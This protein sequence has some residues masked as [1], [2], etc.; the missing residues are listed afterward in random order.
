MKLDEVLHEKEKEKQNDQ[1]KEEMVRRT[2]VGH[3]NP[4]INISPNFTLKYKPAFNCAFD[5]TI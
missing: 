2:F 5:I 3:L 4:I 1:I